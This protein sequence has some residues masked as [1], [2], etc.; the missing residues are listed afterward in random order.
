MQL[1]KIVKNYFSPYD[2]EIEPNSENSGTFNLMVY[3]DRSKNGT[4]N[5]S[6]LDISNMSK[7]R[8]LILVKETKKSLLQE[9]CKFVFDN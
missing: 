5:F 7:N 4:Y 6:Q 8:F 9:D 2:S 1:N 3:K